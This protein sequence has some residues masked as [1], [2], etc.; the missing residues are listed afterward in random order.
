MGSKL[1]FFILLIIF[2]V[3]VCSAGYLVYKFLVL[4]KDEQGIDDISVSDEEIL[5]E[6]PDIY[7]NG[8]IVEIEDQS[9]VVY[10][11]SSGTDEKYYFTSDTECFV[12]DA[13]ND[14]EE[15]CTNVSL[16][17]R[18]DEY[19]GVGSKLIIFSDTSNIKKI[20]IFIS[21]M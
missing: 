7:I 9:V 10:N 16:L 18:V 5:Y 17:E 14:I 13:A 20:S 11:R 8:N 2:L 6:K 4:D 21:D 19:I 15:N 12:V 3:L 1:R